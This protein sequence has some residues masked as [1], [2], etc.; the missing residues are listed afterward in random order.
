MPAHLPTL[1]AIVLAVCFASAVRAQCEPDWIVGAETGYSGANDV[2]RAMFQ[3]EENGRQ[4]LYVGGAFDLVGNGPRGPKIARFD[5]EVWT[6]IGPPL[7]GSTVTIRAVTMLN[8]EVVIGGQFASSAGVPLNNIAR[9][10]GAAW[11][12]FGEGFDGRV[13][14][15]TVYQGELIAAGQFI[16]A[17]QTVCNRIARWDGAQWQPME[18]GLDNECHALAVYR[19]ELYAGGAFSN[20]GGRTAIRIARW[21]GERWRHVQTASLGTVRALLVWNDVLYVGGSGIF[22]TMFTSYP[23]GRWDGARWSPVGDELDGEAYALAVVDGTLYAGGDLS[24]SDAWD[25]PV[26]R[27]EGDVWQPEH[28]WFHALRILA[29]GAIDETLWIGGTTINIGFETFSIIGFDGTNW[30]PAGRGLSDH[31]TGGSDPQNTSGVLSSLVWRDKLIVGGRFVSADLRPVNHLAAWNGWGWMSLGGGVTEWCSYGF[32]GISALAEYQ[33]DLI[34]AGNFHR[35]GDVTMNNI[36]RWDGTSWHSMGTGIGADADCSWVAQAI[37]FQG[38]LVAMGRFDMAGGQPAQNIAQWDGESWSPLGDGL[39]G[40]EANMAIQFEGELVVVGDFD[41]AGGLPANNLA[42]WNGESWREFGGGANDHV[43][44]LCIHDGE[45]YAGGYFTSIGGVPANG[46]AR[47]DGQTWHPLGEGVQGSYPEVAILREHDGRL[48]A[49][50]WFE[51][52]GGKTVHNVASWDGAEWHALGAGTEDYVIDLNSYRGELF[53]GGYFIPTDVY[54]SFLWARWGCPPVIGDADFDGRVDLA[55]LSRLLTAFGACDPAAEY[56]T[57]C[58]FDADG[59][60]TSA[61]LMTLL[62]NYGARR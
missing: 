50:G 48:F 21:N 25:R 20:A 7:E 17:G 19:E 33:G 35:A 45:L 1:T 16:N 34:A 31:V 11:Q 4:V 36:A 54:K 2:V 12:P 39:A 26:F 10:D 37:P 52:A 53:V 46:V 42:A 38:R 59:C 27:L 44:V 40:Y 15:L 29:L 3:A 56:D 23:I 18:T 28:G 9:C 58:D 62:G 5:G 24:R 60:V 61:D 55:D 32:R 49:G 43:N 41:T 13:N 47:W 22:S 14:A 8:G 30:K 57:S 6:P 51:T